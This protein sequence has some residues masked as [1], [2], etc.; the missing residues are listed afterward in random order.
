MPVKT[1]IQVR[2]QFKFKTRLDSGFRRND[3]SRQNLP[4]KLTA[5]QGLFQDLQQSVYHLSACPGNCL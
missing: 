5:V 1:G 4:L 3:R 2:F